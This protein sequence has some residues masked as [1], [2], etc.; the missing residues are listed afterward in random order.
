MKLQVN[1]LRKSY[2]THEVVRD[3]SF[4]IETGEIV[5]LLGPN[6][7]GKTSIVSMLYGAV[8]PDSGESYFESETVRANSADPSSRKLIGIV[9]QENSLDP[10]FP[11]FQNLTLFASYHGIPAKLA[12]EKA[13]QLLEA[14]GLT[15]FARHKVHTL[16]GGMQRRLVLAR[17]LIADPKIIFLDEPTTGFDPDARQDLWALIGTL[18]KEGRSILLTTH[19]M[20]EAERLCD[21]ILLLQAG[22][23]I[24]Q[25]SPE[26]LIQRIVGDE[27][28]EFT[29]ISKIDLLELLSEQR[30][31]RAILEKAESVPFGEGFCLELNEDTE[32]LFD[33]FG[34]SDIKVSRRVTNLEDVFFRLTGDRLR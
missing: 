18:R 29:R 2:G 31:L 27:I 5:G 8:V 16:S 23:I 30:E 11:V 32:R 19:Y 26:N 25:G 28:L 15:E 21:R 9:T 20:D 24:D 22:K 33:H 1:S 13:K 17:S 4:T 14:V 3:V 12:E 10:D 34:A 6:G 7:A